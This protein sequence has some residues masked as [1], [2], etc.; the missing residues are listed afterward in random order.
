MAIKLLGTTEQKENK[1]ENIETKGIFLILW[2]GAPN[3]WFLK[4]SVRWQE[5]QLPF[6]LV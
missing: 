5:I 6:S 4:L 3:G 2:A 1:A